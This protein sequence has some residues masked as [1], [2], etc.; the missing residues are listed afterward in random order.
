MAF[1]WPKK[2]TTKKNKLKEKKK[3]RAPPLPSEPR[4]ERW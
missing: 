4:L 2:T 3:I 1:F